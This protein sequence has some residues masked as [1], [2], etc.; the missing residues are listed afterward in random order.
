MFHS[1]SQCVYVCFTVTESVLC[2]CV[3][4]FHCNRVSVFVCMFHRN[5]VCVRVS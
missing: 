5:R 1:N 4:L 2:V 3:C